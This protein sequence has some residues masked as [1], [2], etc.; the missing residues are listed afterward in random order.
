MLNDTYAP[1]TLTFDSKLNRGHLLV[2][3]N[4]HVKYEDTVMVFKIISGN[5]L[6]YQ[7][8]YISKT[9]YPLFFEG[10]HNNDMK[11]YMFT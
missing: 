1:L 11:P 2:M 10:G 8:T 4:L 5:H 7:P 9:I 6:V 3:N